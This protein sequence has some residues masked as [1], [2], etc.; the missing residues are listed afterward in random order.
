MSNQIIRLLSKVIKAYGISVSQQTIEHTVLTHPE[1]P[2]MQCISDAFKIWKV[3][4]VVATLSLEKLRELDVPV[5][6]HLKKT[7]LC[8]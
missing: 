7:N 2:S 3:K 1:Y 6:A 4:H 8:G 5:I